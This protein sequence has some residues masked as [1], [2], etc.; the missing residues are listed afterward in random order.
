MASIT[1]Q[2]RPTPGERAYTPVEVEVD[3]ALT[4]FA[5]TIEDWVTHRQ[6]WEF[7]LHEGHDF[8]RANNVEG[9]LLFAAGEQTSSVSFRLDQLDAA[10]DFGDELV[11]R[12][13]ERDGIAKTARA[14]ANGF[15]VE[16]HHILTF[17]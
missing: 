3:E 1:V 17:T 16:L 10:E 2:P 5:A 4:V 6:P 9:R 7:T 12:F 11:L 13:E 8:G 14:T 15:D